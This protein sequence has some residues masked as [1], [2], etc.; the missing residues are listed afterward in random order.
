MHS[1]VDTLPHHHLNIMAVLDGLPGVEVTVVVDRKDLH[2]YRDS[3]TVDKEDFVIRYIEVVDGADFA[4]NI[5][6]SMDFEFKGDVLSSQ[7][8]I[9]G[10]PICYAIITPT[11][12]QAGAC[13]CKV[14]GVRM[15]E[16]SIRRLKFRVLETGTRN[17]ASGIELWL[18]VTVSEDD[19]GAS[20]NKERVRN[21]GKIEI[22]VY[23]ENKLGL[24]TSNNY[25]G[26]TINESVISEKD[27]KGKAITHTYRYPEK[28]NTAGRNYTDDI[29]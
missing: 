3:D 16:N 21:L 4:V 9:D 10:T 19:A 22:R 5:K 29:L 8:S 1:S 23:H 25:Q 12:V 18:T 7:V 6:T 26:P 14:G 2:E 11:D 24:D 13:N 15:D 17:Y 27:I 20:G 28:E